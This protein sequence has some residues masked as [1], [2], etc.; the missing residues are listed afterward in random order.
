[1]Q[2]TTIET[3]KLE[4]WYRLND[5]T[6]DTFDNSIKD[7]SGKDHSGVITGTNPTQEIPILIAQLNP[8]NY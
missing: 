2:P 1:M 3:N 7:S 4:L 6:N 5:F 8:I